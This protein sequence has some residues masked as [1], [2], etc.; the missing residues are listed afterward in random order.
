[1]VPRA[2]RGSNM[3][4]ETGFACSVYARSE[5]ATV[6]QGI[7]QL[8]AQQLSTLRKGAA[9]PPRGRALARPHHQHVQFTPHAARSLPTPP[10]PHARELCT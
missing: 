1:M 5:R 9:R 2:A 3:C 7:G 4:D 10:M 8:A 6:V